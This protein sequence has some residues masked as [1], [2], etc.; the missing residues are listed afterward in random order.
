MKSVVEGAAS[1]PQQMVTVNEDELVLNLE[2]TLIE[3]AGEHPLCGQE[4]FRGS[5]IVNAKVQKMTPHVQFD[6]VVQGLLNFDSLWEKNETSK[7]RG[8]LQDLCGQSG[9]AVRAAGK[10]GTMTKV[11]WKDSPGEKHIGD[12]TFKST[13]YVVDDNFVMTHSDV[14]LNSSMV[15]DLD[16]FT[17]HKT[18][19]H[20]NGALCMRAYMYRTD[21]HR[22]DVLVTPVMKNAL[23]VGVCVSSLDGAALDNKYVRWNS[24]T[25]DFFT[26][27]MQMIYN[28]AMKM[29]VVHLKSQIIRK[30][31]SL[32]S[33]QREVVDLVKKQHGHNLKSQK[34]LDVFFNRLKGAMTANEKKMFES[35]PVRA[36][37]IRVGNVIVNNFTMSF[38]KIDLASC[39]IQ[40]QGGVE[41]KQFGNVSVPKVH[42]SN[43]FDMQ[44]VV[45]SYGQRRH[46]RQGR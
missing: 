31:L 41:S 16:L 36:V 37:D 38:G 12:K 42:I 43:V 21:T 19:K 14:C 4:L 15:D 25:Y 8:K 29:G 3:C 35:Y 34:T 26:S 28:R 6:V 46:F 30:I 20:V 40:V 13:K 11:F 45:F 2:C 18:L 27:S 5:R 7:L 9:G 39:K 17:L 1:S 22:L 24:D 10:A 33:D 32:R 23:P 44:N